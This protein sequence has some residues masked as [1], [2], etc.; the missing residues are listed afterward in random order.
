MLKIKCFGRRWLLTRII[1]NH[2]L[3]VTQRHTTTTYGVAACL[4]RLADTEWQR[5]CECVRRFSPTIGPLGQWRSLCEGGWTGQVPPGLPDLDGANGQPNSPIERGQAEREPAG[6]MTIGEETRQPSQPQAVPAQLT[7]EPQQLVPPS[8]YST[9]LPS[10]S[11]SSNDLPR[12]QVSARSSPTLTRQQQQSTTTPVIPSETVPVPPSPQSLEPPVSP[13]VD[14]N[15]GSVRSLSAFPTPPTHFPLP[16]PR[17]PRGQQTSYFQQNPSSTN[18]ELPSVSQRPPESP[19]SSNGDLSG[20]SDTEETMSRPTIQNLR[21]VPTAT[22]TSTQP[23]PEAKYKTP[24]IPLEEQVSNEQLNTP[25]PEVQRPTP[26]RSQTALT[27]ESNIDVDSRQKTRQ[28]PSSSIDTSPQTSSKSYTR[29]DHERDT[30]EFGTLNRDAE[31]P[32]KSRTVDSSKYQQAIERMDTG[33]SSGSIV[34]AMRNRYSNTVR[35]V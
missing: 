26:V 6:L 25:A 5:S 35:S 13:Y 1:S 12:D 10:A 4:S 33:A 20:I 24:K 30:R 34:A 14:Q 2:T 28:G 29:D 19:L 17:Q 8:G 9:T 27:V 3:S 16:P 32:A 23:S 18:L 31:I 11:E 7:P 15:T 22:T 21:D